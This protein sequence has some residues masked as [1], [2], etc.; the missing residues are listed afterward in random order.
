MVYT[1]STITEH[2]RYEARRE[3]EVTGENRGIQ[4]GMQIGI[5]EG[6]QIGA[7]E[8]QIASLQ[9]LHLKGLLPDDVFER[10]V[11]PLKNQLEALQQ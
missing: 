8:G 3:G 5:Q 4:I 9:A 10:K 11:A 2:I 7:V 6:M 1:G